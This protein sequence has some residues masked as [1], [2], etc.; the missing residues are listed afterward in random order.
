MNHTDPHEES[1]ADLHQE[2]VLATESPTSEIAEAPD[3]APSPLVPIG[4]VDTN[5][6]LATGLFV[7]VI[8]V[9]LVIIYAFS[10]AA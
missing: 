3:S 8:G 4:D 9:L 5:G 7:G 1:T 6:H 10:M 2:T